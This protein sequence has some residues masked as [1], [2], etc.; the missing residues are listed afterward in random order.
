M[1]I[2]SV[3]QMINKRSTPV[4]VS[5]TYYYLRFLGLNKSPQMYSLGIF[6]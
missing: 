6:E 5:R 1:S 2:P 4:G 3:G